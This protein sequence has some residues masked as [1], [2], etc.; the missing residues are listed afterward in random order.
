MAFIVAPEL[1]AYAEAHTTPP[2]PHL[3]ALAEETQ[4]TLDA[5][6][7]MV[8]AL[9]GR[10]LEFLVF[11]SRAERVLEIGTFSGYSSLSMAAALGVTGRITTLELS[12]RHAEVARRH[13][14]AS[15]YAERI[16]VVVGPALDS[17]A[18]LDGPWDLVFIDA[19]KTNYANYYESVLPK[20]ADDGLIAV[21]NVLWSGRVLDPSDTSPDTAAIVA[22]NDRVRSD[23]RVTCVLCTV[24]DGVLLIR[25]NP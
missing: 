5:P 3:V 6:Q 14:A 8:G 11:A 13:I 23:S 20:L 7:M 25:K 1:E 12:E 24:R 9:E 22:F 19:D 18:R 4:R 16:E 10:F 21:D 17:L 15:P 2:P